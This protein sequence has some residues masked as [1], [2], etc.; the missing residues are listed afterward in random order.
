MELIKTRSRALKCRKGSMELRACGFCG[1]IFNA[2]FDPATQQFSESYE[3]S[4]GHSPTFSRFAD[5]LVEK[6]VSTHD[7]YE[8]TILEVGCGDG[9]FLKGLCRRGNT[10]GIGMDP[11]LPPGLET[12]SGGIHFIRQR[13][14]SN[15][16][17]A[18][19]DF[20]CCRMTLEHIRDVRKILMAAKACLKENGTLFFQVPDVKR[21]LDKGAFWDI[22]YEHCSYF[23]EYSL[24]RLFSGMGFDSQTVWSDYKGQYLCL[25]A[26]S[27]GSPARQS[28]LSE[29]L[30]EIGQS[31]SRFEKA[32]KNNINQWIKKIHTESGSGR[33]TVIWGSSSKGVSFLNTLGIIDEIR[34]VVDINPR[35][36]GTF[37][38]GSG[39]EIIPA[40]RLK[41]I[42]PDLVI[43][44]NPVYLGEIQALLS[45]LNLSPEVLA[46]C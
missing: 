5:A 19:P 29:P 31:I 8:K 36:Q 41:T 39:Q 14:P 40:D 32:W 6:L 35:R 45:G 1:F 34:Y 24:A 22:Y 3:A 15:K 27:G 23:G 16:L 26:R 44:M 12:A 21:I 10:T 25:S 13:F 43:V 33:K 4:Q 20:F 30:K 2:A 18:R 38:A 46:L 28:R 42:K 11:A 17:H 37:M 9:K 7:L